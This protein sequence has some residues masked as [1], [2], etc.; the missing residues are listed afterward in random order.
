MRRAGLIAAAMVAGWYLLTLAIAGPLVN[1]PVVD[2]WLYVACVRWLV[3]TGEL[4]LA[5]FQSAMPVLQMYYGAAWGMLFGL[6]HGSL[7]ISVALLGASTAVL[8]HALALRCGAHPRN[9][10]LATGLLICNPCYLFLS[11]S[12]MTE[13]P[14]LALMIGALLAFARAGDGRETAWLWTSAALVVA[15]FLVR[16]FAGAVAAGCIAAVLLYDFDPAGAQDLKRIAKRVAPYAIAVSAC[17]IIWL[18][19]TVLKPLPWDFQR[20]VGR[21]ALLFRVPIG[22]YVLGGVLGPALNLG[23]LLSPLAVLQWRRDRMA[24]M[25]GVA[26]AIFALTA[27]LVRIYPDAVEPEFSCFGG[28][29]NVLQLRGL[30]LRYF[31]KDGGRL[32]AVGLG[33]VGAVGLS[34]AAR[35]VI[36]SLNRAAAAVFITAALYWLAM[37]PLWF[38]NDRYDIV[39][40]PAGCLLLALAP[41]PRGRLA[42]AAAVAMLAVLGWVAIAGVY[43][44]QRGITAVVAAR[45]AL[46]KSGVPRAKID[47]GYA[48][49]GEDLYRYP[50]RGIDTMAFEAGIPLITTLDLSEY[51]VAAAPIAGTTIIA[52]YQWPGPLGMGH[53]DVYV[54]KREH[55]NGR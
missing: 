50:K 24:R 28:W 18:W 14:F 48:L 30:P 13:I 21:F 35:D 22:T 45:D 6:S 12:F 53:R 25:L 34:M 32:L 46:L 37:V 55:A 16:P 8:F 23:A 38:F 15:G 44:Y 41:H 1:A 39:L 33:S 36:A 43:D 2:G 54:L 20:R 7:E 19:L 47:A 3:R 29:A 27:Y 26:A 17:A 4:R 10:L 42:S 49:N 51:T 31:W 9:A 11:F 40:L 5:G 52:R